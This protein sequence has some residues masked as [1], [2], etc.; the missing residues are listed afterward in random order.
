MST[1]RE[2]SVTHQ[3]ACVGIVSFILFWGA[4]AGSA[5]FSMLGESDR[6]INIMIYSVLLK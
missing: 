3:Y 1:G 4:G 2:L 6:V 5:V